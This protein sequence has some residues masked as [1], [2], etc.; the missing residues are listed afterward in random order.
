MILLTC[1]KLL[2]PGTGTGND[3]N[4]YKVKSEVENVR[5]K[6]KLKAIIS[7]VVCLCFFLCSRF[8]LSVQCV[9]RCIVSYC[10]CCCAMGLVA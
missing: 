8:Y 7:L 4:W 1:G 9:L 6:G 10:V 3:C 2:S 5:S